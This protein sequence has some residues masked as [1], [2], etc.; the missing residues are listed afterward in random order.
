MHKKLNPVITIFLLIKLLIHLSSSILI[1]GFHRL[2]KNSFVYLGSAELAA[3]CSRLGRIPTIEEYLEQ[4]GV[5]A[6]AGAE[7]YR[8][9]NFN[10]IDSYVEKASTVTA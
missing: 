4:T 9:M 7:V 5:L 10:E 8:Y 1:S 3:V 2:G 6:D